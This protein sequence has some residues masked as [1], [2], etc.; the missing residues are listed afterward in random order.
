MPRTSANLISYFCC[1][2]LFNMECLMYGLLFLQLSTFLGYFRPRTFFL[3]NGLDRSPWTSFI[4]YLHT[5]VGIISRNVLGSATDF[6]CGVGPWMK[7]LTPVWWSKF[8]FMFPNE[9][10]CVSLTWWRGIFYRCLVFIIVFIRWPNVTFIIPHIWFHSE[11]TFLSYALGI[12]IF[13]RR[14]RYR[15]PCYKQRTTNIAV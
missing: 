14:C 10:W 5:I 1:H 9:S 13:H 8:R 15:A 7:C 12:T 6:P 11:I 3:K 2:Y 4:S